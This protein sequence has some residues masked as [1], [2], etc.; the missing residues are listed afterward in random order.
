MERENGISRRIAMW[1]YFGWFWI[2]LFTLIGWLVDTG[3]RHY[4]LSLFLAL[5]AARIL[6]IT[7]IRVFSRPILLRDSVILVGLLSLLYM[8]LH[9]LKE[10]TGVLLI[11]E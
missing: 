6:F 8:E 11:S 7:A 10:H 2:Y 9:W 4:Y 5:L 1:Y 3:F